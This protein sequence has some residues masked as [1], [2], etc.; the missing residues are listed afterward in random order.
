MTATLSTS[1]LLHFK[2]HV[3]AVIDP[4]RDPGAYIRVPVPVDLHPILAASKLLGHGEGCDAVSCYTYSINDTANTLCTP[5]IE[6]GHSSSS[7][8][9]TPYPFKTRQP[10]VTTAMSAHKFFTRGPGRKSISD[11]TVGCYV[12]SSGQ[13]RPWT[14]TRLVSVPMAP[15]ITTPHP[16]E[17]LVYTGSRHLNPRHIVSTASRRTPFLNHSE[18]GWRPASLAMPR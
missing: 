16:E 11:I 7:C 1:M 3:V 13:Q 9:T 10:P 5:N 12:P 8:A 6:F 17:L 2:Y 4:E 18:Q 15:S 14:A